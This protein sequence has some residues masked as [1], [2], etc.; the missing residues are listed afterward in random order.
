[1]KILKVIGFVSLFLSVLPINNKA[2]A[3]DDYTWHC[4]YKHNGEIYAVKLVYASSC[5]AAP[6]PPAHESDSD[7]GS[8]E[9]KKTDH[10][11]CVIT[12]KGSRP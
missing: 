2:Y 3:W 5:P 9:S 7:T 6:E 11:D 8:E 10:D 1:M 4:E 12:T